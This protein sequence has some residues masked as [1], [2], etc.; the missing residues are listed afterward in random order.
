M[1]RESE[2][3]A[4]DFIGNVVV[5]HASILA[6]VFGVGCTEHHPPAKVAIVKLACHGKALLQNNTVF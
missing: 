1:R 3:D 4:F 5:R 2:A 6:K